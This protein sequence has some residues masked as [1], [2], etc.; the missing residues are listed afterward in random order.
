MTSQV[1]EPVYSGIVSVEELRAWMNQPNFNEEQEF[2]A[3]M[4]LAG[5]QDDLEEYLNRPVEP[6][7]M[8]ELLVADAQGYVTPSITPIL[9]V[10]SVTA[11]T[12]VGF[13]LSGWATPYMPPVMERDPLIDPTNGRMQDNLLPVVGDPIILASGIFAGFPFSQF[14]VEYIGGYN[15]FHINGMKKAIMIVA[16]RSMAPN[17]DKSFSLRKGDPEKSPETDPRVQ[18]WT[19]DELKQWE[20]QRRRVMA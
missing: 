9:K 3:S 18:G 20:R 15:G 5:T 14:A 16:S 2:A 4:A 6:V 11:A 1:P 17:H 7:Q 8:R 19:E 12:D 10:L 13:D